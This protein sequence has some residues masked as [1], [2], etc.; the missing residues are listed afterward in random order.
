[1]AID[2]TAKYPG[3]FDPVS[4]LYPQGKFKNR[5]APNTEDGSYMERDWLNDWNGFFGALLK[6]AGV[7]PNGTVD[8]AAASQLYDALRF[9]MLGILPKRSFA[10]I[11]FIRIPDVPGGLIIQWGFISVPVNSTA[12]VNLP[13][14]FPTSPLQSL[15]SYDN[16]DAAEYPTLAIGC[17]TNSTIRAGVKSA[18]GSNFIVRYIAVG[19]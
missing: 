4:A 8:T 18:L 2:F 10:S 6:N 19:F 5:S 3:R 15:G 9:L 17:P 1:M 16:P 7:T 14:A 12:T 11:D 13:I